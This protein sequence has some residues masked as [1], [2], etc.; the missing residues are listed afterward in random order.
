M[1]QAAGLAVNQSTWDQ[2]D[3]LHQQH[4]ADESMSG[5]VY[6]QVQAIHQVL[7]ESMVSAGLT[8]E[9]LSE[10]V[11]QHVAA[12]LSMETLH[13]T[14]QRVRSNGDGVLAGSRHQPKGEVAQQQSEQ[15]PTR[16][17]S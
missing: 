11:R 1:A 13:V 5:L 6:M 15:P 14:V 9:S 12:G 17:V 3:Q 8:A 16:Q 4:S 2:L 7:G 10:A